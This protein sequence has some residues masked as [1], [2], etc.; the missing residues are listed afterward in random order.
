MKRIGVFSR[1]R[2]R[3]APAAG[4]SGEDRH[5]SSRFPEGD[6]RIYCRIFFSGHAQVSAQERAAAGSPPAGQGGFV[7]RDRC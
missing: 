7:D 3:P 6:R 4:L 5:K 1:D 2:A